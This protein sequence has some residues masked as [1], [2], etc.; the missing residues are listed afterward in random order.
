MPSYPIEPRGWNLVKLQAACLIIHGNK[1]CPGM[2]C[3]LVRA[4]MSIASARTGA[5]IVRCARSAALIISCSARMMGSKVVFRGAR[6]ARTLSTN[7]TMEGSLSCFS[8]TSSHLMRIY[9]FS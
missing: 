4:F 9:F 6:K 8:R 2:T 1:T 7:W 5:A 3:S